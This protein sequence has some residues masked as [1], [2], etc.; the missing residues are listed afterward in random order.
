MI[1]G[2]EAVDQ[3]VHVVIDIEAVAADLCRSFSSSEPDV[4][5]VPQTITIPPLH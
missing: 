5:A 4:I 2:E 1:I 3:A